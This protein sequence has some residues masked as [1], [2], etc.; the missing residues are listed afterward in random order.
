MANLFD[1]TKTNE[2]KVK[3]WWHRKKIQERVDWCNAAGLGGQAGSREWAYMGLNDLYNLLQ[4]IDLNSGKLKELQMTVGKTN[5][6]PIETVTVEAQPMAE[7]NKEPKK[8]IFTGKEK[9]NVKEK[10]N[11]IM[12]E[13]AE[14]KPKVEKVVTTE[15]ETS[16]KPGAIAKLWDGA[17]NRAKVSM[18]TSVGCRKNQFRNTWADLD[19]EDKN[20]IM[21]GDLNILSV[22]GH[23]GKAGKPEAG[24]KKP[25]AQKPGKD[26]LE[27]IKNLVGGATKTDTGLNFG[28]LILKVKNVKAVSADVYLANGT[29]AKGV[30]YVIFVAKKD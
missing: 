16:I 18:L 11:K 1:L 7:A 5:G 15:T 20:M 26:V 28:D 3:N 21:T 17:T 4:V 8:D 2:G 22:R 6:T 9:K 12:K 19:K 23:A 27:Q 10:L 29:D 13:T 30:K 24:E 14:K 25:K